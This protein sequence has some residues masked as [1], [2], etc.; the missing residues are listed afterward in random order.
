[1]AEPTQYVFTYPEVVEALIKKQGL[2][3]GR[4]AIYMEFGIAAANAGPT[5]EQAVPSAIVPV[6]KVGLQRVDAD[7]TLPGTLD[8]A[9]VNPAAP[10]LQ[11]RGGRAIDPEDA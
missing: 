6:I 9:V 4:W 5:P 11:V 2:H 3:E 8:A 1:M 10:A 7:K